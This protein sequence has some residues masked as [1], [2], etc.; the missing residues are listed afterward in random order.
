MEAGLDMDEDLAH[1]GFEGSFIGLF[2]GQKTIN[3]DFNNGVELS[4]ASGGHEE[5]ATNFGATTVD[6]S[7]V[8]DRAAP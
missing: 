8:G 6:G 7:S 2:T 1:F 3:I 4:G 5:N